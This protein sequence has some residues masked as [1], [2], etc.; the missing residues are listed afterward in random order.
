[1]GQHISDPVSEISLNL[2]GSEHSRMIVITRWVAKKLTI[3]EAQIWNLKVARCFEVSA[4][5]WLLNLGKLVGNLIMV[6]RRRRKWLMSGACTKLIVEF[7]TFDMGFW[8]EVVQSF[9]D[10]SNLVST[11]IAKT[12]VCMRWIQLSNVDFVGRTKQDVWQCIAHH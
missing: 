6:M 2:T 12:S 3:C 11:F 7:Q 9:R 5:L 10:F 1:M 4:K 8:F